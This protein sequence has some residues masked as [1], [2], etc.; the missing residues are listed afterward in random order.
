M[1]KEHY[2]LALAACRYSAAQRGLSIQER[3]LPY[4][5]KYQVMGKLNTKNLKEQTVGI[6]I[7]I[8]HHL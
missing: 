6:D 2:R 7:E 4:W 1:R 3:L 5:G 8:K